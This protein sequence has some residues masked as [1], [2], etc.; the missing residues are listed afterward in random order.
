[1]KPSFSSLL[2]C[3]LAT[4]AL[5]LSSSAAAAQSVPPTT[6]GSPNPDAPDQIGD[7]AELIGTH[8]CSS[9]Q[10]APDETFPDPIQAKWRF[11]Y[12]FDGHAVQDETW[13]EDGT[14]TSSIRQY[15]PDSSAWMV[16][17][18][19]SGP[20]APSPPTWQGSRDGN[21]IVLRRSQKSPNG[22][23]G[24]SRLTFSNISEGGFEWIGEW[25]SLDGSVVFPFWRI[26]CTK[27]EDD[28]HEFGWLEGK[29]RNVDNGSVEAWTLLAA[30]ALKGRTTITRPDG[31][32]RVLEELMLYRSGDQWYY[33]PDVAQNTYPVPF[34]Y[35]RDG[36]K[37]VFVNET[38]D[39]P[40]QIVYERGALNALMVWISDLDDSGAPVNRMDFRFVR[41]D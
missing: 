1:M 7:Y 38:H 13:K 36:S 24:I 32:M 40:K 30:D 28:E 35:S 23:D 8:Q 10:R 41:A 33:V 15:N 16:T 6:Y 19:A 18:F 12:I 34:E 2:L 21:E 25:V 9:A 29:W 31:S 22:L 14:Y 39:Y 37:H 27:I 17:Y 26:G 11:K 4:A 5:L 3:A 20:G